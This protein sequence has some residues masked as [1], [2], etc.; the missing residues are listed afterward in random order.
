MHLVRLHDEHIAQEPVARQ[1]G[2]FL[3]RLGYLAS[4]HCPSSLW[5]QGFLA[6]FTYQT[7]MEHCCLCT[8]KGTQEPSPPNWSLSVAAR[9]HY[10]HVRSRSIGHNEV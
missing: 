3:S 2:S 8:T 6:L 5:P 1:S 7:I 4:L 10:S 9:R